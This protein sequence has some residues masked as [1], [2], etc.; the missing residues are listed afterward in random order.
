MIGFLN[1]RFAPSLAWQGGLHTTETDSGHVVYD[2]LKGLALSVLFCNFSEGF[3][4]WMSTNFLEN[5]EP[6]RGLEP[7]TC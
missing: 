5:L 7:R 6:A 2:D 3:C 1:E 4:G